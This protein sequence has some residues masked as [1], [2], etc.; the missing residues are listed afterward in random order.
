MT[1]CSTRCTVSVITLR[2]EVTLTITFHYC[3]LSAK[4]H[5]LA[6]Y[7]NLQ[8]TSPQR[9]GAKFTQ[10]KHEQ[11]VP[12]PPLKGT[13]NEYRIFNVDGLFFIFSLM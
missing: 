9:P 8:H 10:M 1:V 11:I 4:G 12:F 5:G 6:G 7:R 3:M 2:S 13:N